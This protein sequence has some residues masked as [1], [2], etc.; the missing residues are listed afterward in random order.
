MLAV[1][2]ICS[3][4]RAARGINGHRRRCTT[5]EVAGARRERV[6][7]SERRPLRTPWLTRRT[8][9]QPPSLA[10]CPVDSVWRPAPPGRAAAKQ[11]TTYEWRLLRLN[12]TPGPTDPAAPSDKRRELAGAFGSLAPYRLPPRGTRGRAQPADN[13]RTI[14][15][16]HSTNSAGWRHQQP[17]VRGWR[18]AF[19]IEH[20]PNTAFVGRSPAPPG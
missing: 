19:N 7:V 18:D 10:A 8:S 12:E 5:T 4:C 20:R 9:T 1:V 11:T 13:Q 14:A 6:S 2:A 17:Q 3:C 15:S 16:S